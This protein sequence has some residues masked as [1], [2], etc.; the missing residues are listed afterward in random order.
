MKLKEYMKKDGINV[1][2]LSKMTG[3]SYMTLNDLYKGITPLTKTSS[4]NLYRISRSIHIPMEELLSD[5]ILEEEVGFSIPSALIN[6]IKEILSYDD[7][8]YGFKI[9]AIDNLENFSKNYCLEGILTW[10]QREAIIKHF[11]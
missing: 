9:D 3:I 8:P 11:C 1:S 4:D 6:I 2:R 10:E 5:Y 7:D